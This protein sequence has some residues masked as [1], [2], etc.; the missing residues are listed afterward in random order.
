ML[1]EYA[2]VLG[3]NLGIPSETVEDGK[4]GV[5]SISHS[6]LRP[7][8][9]GGK[10]YPYTVRLWLLAEAEGDLD[11]FFFFGGGGHSFRPCFGGH[12]LG[13]PKGIWPWVKIQI[14]FQ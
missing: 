1:R 8:H 7:S 14:E 10:S 13:G 3:M 2:R 6:L 5:Q 11:P 9:W 12:F 4:K